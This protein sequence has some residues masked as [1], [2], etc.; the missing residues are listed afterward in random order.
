MDRLRRHP[1][2]VATCVGV[3]ALVFGVVAAG[4]VPQAKAS[5]SGWNIVVGGPGSPAD[6][7]SNALLLGDTCADA[8]SC[9]AFGVS[10]PGSG[11]NASQVGTVADPGP[12]GPVQA[13]PA[14]DQGA[15]VPLQS[16][17]TAGNLRQ[18]AASSR[19]VLE[20]LVMVHGSGRRAFQHH[21]LCALWRHLRDAVRLLGRRR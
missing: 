5:P 2:R 9:W 18:R 17:A 13:A 7:T 21:R 8:W 16:G 19:R 6:A 1:V 14:D 11:N 10:D 15:P 20:R 3:V 4:F 12:G